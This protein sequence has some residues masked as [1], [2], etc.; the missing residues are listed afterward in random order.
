MKY[1]IEHELPHENDASVKAHTDIN[2]FLQEE[3]YTHRYFRTRSGSNKITRE[4]YRL[5]SI[6]T[7]RCQIKSQDTVL[8]QYPIYS[9]KLD[10][11]VFYNYVVRKAKKKICIVHDLPFLRDHD[12]I[13]HREMKNEIR[14]L[15]LFDKVIVH[16]ERMK[17][18][19]YECGVTTDMIVLG[20]FDYS[21]K[22][23]AKKKIEQSSFQVP[24]N[25][26]FAGNLNK[27][28]FVKQLKSSGE[29]HYH[30]W[31]RIENAE[32]L[33]S[34]VSYHGVVPSDELPSKLKDGWGLV[35]D[36][37]STQNI[38][39][40]GGAYLRYID[41]HKTSLYLVSG[42]PVIVWDKAGVAEFI[43]TNK[44]GITVKSVKNLKDELEKLTA[45]DFN[46]IMKS[47]ADYSVKLKNGC[48]IKSAVKKAEMSSRK[49]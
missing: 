35:W 45:T 47:V 48:M 13:N 12:K 25:V 14:R 38:E 6:I 5:K 40:K 9:S 4:L 49:R 26:F 10:T 29:M 24:M 43:R 31:G 39:G 37:K 28:S 8:I 42:V 22:Y 19:L 23:D 17:E 11:D 7:L 34:T 32:Q 2:N 21:T 16:N 20:I 44:L 15:N 1:L 36:G 41:P 30:L 3:G 46:L 27:S 33:D 18:K